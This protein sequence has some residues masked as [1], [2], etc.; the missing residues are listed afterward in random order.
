MADKWK[1]I[2]KALGADVK[3]G[4]EVSVDNVDSAGEA[5]DENAS[6][7]ENAGKHKRNLEKG[8][9]YK[10]MNQEISPLLPASIRKIMKNTP[11]IAAADE[12]GNL[13]ENYIR[14]RSARMKK[15]HN[16]ISKGV[17]GDL[18][19]VEEDKGKENLA[20][21]GITDRIQQRNEL[22]KQGEMGRK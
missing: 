20:G 19:V 13:K 18:E 17:R 12:K 9:P 21:E 16:V 22:A 14:V 7:S 6:I 3:D 8:Y 5:D 1:R 15:I 4:D 11:S 10:D 2:A